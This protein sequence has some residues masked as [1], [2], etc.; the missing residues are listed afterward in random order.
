MSA[1][2]ALTS[3]V[4]YTSF[5]AGSFRP[6]ASTINTSIVKDKTTS[7]G[8]RILSASVKSDIKTDVFLYKKKQDIFISFYQT[9]VC[10][11]YCIFKNSHLKA[12]MT[13]P[14]HGNMHIGQSW[15]IYHYG[16]VYSEFKARDIVFH[17]Q[18]NNNCNFT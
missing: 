16:Q 17:S 11:G 3:M 5:S 12:Y 10:Y 2:Q 4:Q 13:F 9:F 6:L 15:Q 18:L 7:E 1:Q 8:E 14:G